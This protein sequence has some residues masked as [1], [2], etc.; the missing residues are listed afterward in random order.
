M[1]KESRLLVLGTHNKKKGAELLDL[2]KPLGFDLKTLADIPDAI[3]VEET[4]TTFSE[5]AALKATE[6]A[7]HLKQWVL[8]EDSGLSVD[9]LNGAPGVY[10]AR[11]SGLEATDESNNQKLL[12]AL[13]EVDIAKRTAYYT[14][15]M[16]L[17]NP[18]GEVM[19]ESTGQCHGRILRTQ[20]GTGGFG[21]DPLFLVPEYHKT[22]GVLGDAVKAVISHRARATRIMVQQL[23]RLR[24]V[25]V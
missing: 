18:Q 15:H 25:W 12:D 4:G 14:C 17:S 16:T 13:R 3:E 20:H 1:A 23:E 24:D 6:Q 22:F 10:S 5:N 19:A 11:Y 21:Y 7:R 9:A 2:L 8:G